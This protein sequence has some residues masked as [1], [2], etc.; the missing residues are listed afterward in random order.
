MRVIYSEEILLRRVGALA[1]LI[2]SSYPDV[3]DSSDLLVLGLLKGSFLFVAD[4]VRRM[5]RPHHV[6]F[7]VAGSYGA[8]TKSSG[9]VKI[10]YEPDLPITGRHVLVVE[11]IIETGNTLN[12][13]CRY[14]EK[15]EPRTLRTCTLLHKRVAGSLEYEPKFVGFDAPRSF[16]VGYGLDHA[17]DYRHLPWIASIED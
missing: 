11:D 1:A 10:K 13:V 15:K 4:L 7:I 9:E 6:D 8:D 12:H 3:E 5:K 14:L 17:E 16:L 2:D